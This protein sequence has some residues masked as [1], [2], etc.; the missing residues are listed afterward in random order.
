MTKTFKKNGTLNIPDL[1]NPDWHKT[2]VKKHKIFVKSAYCPT[3]HNLMS[4]V[5]IDDHKGIHF[6][7]RELKSNREAD[8]VI[9]AR[10]GDCTK[11]Y[12][13]GE[14]FNDGEIVAIYCPICK[15]E[16]H[17]HGDCECGSHDYLFYLDQKLDKNCAQTFCSKIGCAKASKLHVA[18]D[19][20]SVVHKEEKT[21]ITEAYCSNGHNLISDIK[22]DQHKGL[23]FI[24]KE[25]EGNKEAEIVVTATVGNSKKVILKGE[26][27]KEDQ[28]V[29]IHCPTC[30]EKLPILFDCECGAPIY[31]FFLDKSMNYNYGQS[32]CSRIGC[33]KSSRL[34]L[35]E[36]MLREFMVRHCS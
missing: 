20:A 25:R 10:V 7:Y 26:P 34:Q 23:H 19:E 15:T 28:I 2:I 35:S 16:L 11:V 14:A 4:D 33:V 29:D 17:T 5:K 24:Y 27:F 36:E 6:L 12:L 21:V 22:I 31:M 9:S 8:I 32:F 30:R 3:G 13:K 18:E 1:K